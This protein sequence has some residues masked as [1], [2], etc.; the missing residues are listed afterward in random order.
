MQEQDSDEGKTPDIPLNKEALAFLKLIF[1]YTSVLV[2][3]LGKVKGDE[4]IAKLFKQNSE[5][6]YATIFCFKAIGSCVEQAKDTLEVKDSLIPLFWKNLLYLR[7]ALVHH[8]LG[9]LLP[10]DCLIILAKIT[11]NAGQIYRYFSKVCDK[12]NT[13]VDLEGQRYKVFIE[14]HELSRFLQK[15]FS[16][17]VRAEKPQ[18]EYLSL[19]RRLISIL[20]KTIEEM[21]LTEQGLRELKRAN[22]VKY[23]AI[24]N[25]LEFI[26]TLANPSPEFAVLTEESRQKIVGIH[27][28]AD[29]WFRS[30][31]ESRIDFMHTT[32]GVIPDKMLVRHLK[33]MCEIDLILQQNAKLKKEPIKPPVGVDTPSK[34]VK[35]LGIPPK[36]VTETAPKQ[37]P[38]KIPTAKSATIKQPGG[39]VPPKIAK[40]S[41]NIA[42]TP[43]KSPF[44]K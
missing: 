15:R 1:I 40:G 7:T 30:L 12:K 25:C 21:E 43:K 17:E 10:D 14:V 4:E 13:G 27:K 2:D 5:L 44:K 26:A 22:P 19:L 38:Q 29:T 36:K 20:C 11:Q 23:Y 16:R 8:S 41:T 6:Q 9:L 31:G 42:S 18:E 35:E 37:Q 39:V 33:D 24:Q 32:G 3:S 34:I 28:D